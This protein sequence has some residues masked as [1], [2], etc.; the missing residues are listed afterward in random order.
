MTEQKID[1]N[2]ID[3]RIQSL[4]KEALA[5]KDLSDGFP[6]LA[7]NTARILASLKM[8]EINVSDVRHMASK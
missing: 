2:N 6:A 4:K 7:R 8:I 1:L 3:E 5:L